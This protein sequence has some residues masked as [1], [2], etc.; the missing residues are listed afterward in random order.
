M[1][2][3]GPAPVSTAILSSDV[4]C[5]DLRLNLLSV[6]HVCSNYMCSEGQGLNDR[7]PREDRGSPN[8]KILLRNLK[9]MSGLGFLTFVLFRQI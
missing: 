9:Q 5:L 8:V 1:L 3:G 4:T 6:L 2:V 7:D